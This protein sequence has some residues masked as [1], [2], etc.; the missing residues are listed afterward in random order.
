MLL[1]HE[2]ILG[3]NISSALVDAFLYHSWPPA[4]RDEE[5][6]PLVL[7]KCW[8][9]ELPHVEEPFSNEAINKLIFFKIWSKTIY[10]YKINQYST[11]IKQARSLNKPYLLWYW[12]MK[13]MAS[14]GW[15]NRTL[16]SF[17]KVASGGWVKLQ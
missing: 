9:R 2:A 10:L 5:M 17:F 8:S 4:T 3:I 13:Y 14:G 15:N 12:K 16:I 7:R 11:I 6:H 1:P